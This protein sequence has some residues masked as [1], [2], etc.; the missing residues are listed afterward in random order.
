M[1]AEKLKHK[2]GIGKLT[3]LLSL[4][5]ILN[6]Q[7]WAQDSA[8][9]STAAD[10][11]ILENPDPFSLDAESAVYCINLLKNN[12]FIEKKDESGKY[13]IIEVNTI[14]SWFLDFDESYPEGHRRRYDIIV[15][16]T[17]LNWDNS[18]IEYGSEMI[19]LRLL[20]LYRN[21]YPPKSLEYYYNPE[22]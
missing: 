14:W 3:L 21:Q 11:I 8:A 10:N 22:S 6:T 2:R 7:L 17:P 19:N 18:Y 13:K 20:F 16:E 5:L 9:S 12:R 1:A 4:L 15:N